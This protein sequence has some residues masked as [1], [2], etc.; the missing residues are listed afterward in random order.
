M[1]YAF[2][3]PAVQEAVQH[4]EVGAIAVTLFEWS[5]VAVQ[6]QSIAWTR[7]SDGES[8]DTFADLIGETARS[9]PGGSTAI[10]DALSF[11]GNLF[12]KSGFRSPRHVI[13]VSGDGSNNSGPAPDAIRDRL[14]DQG[15]TI[16]GLAIL[17]DEPNLH[18]YYGAAVIGGEGAF[19]LTAE[20]YQSFANAIINKLVK[21]IAGNDKAREPS[22]RVQLAEYGDRD[23][24][25]E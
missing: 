8:F 15:I 22:L 2:H 5:S 14:V 24:P 6:H 16:N 13:D 7:L 20:N 17:S 10:G 19:V 11:A 4:G 23:L 12:E 1:S 3:H 25:Y 21:E 18:E 9:V